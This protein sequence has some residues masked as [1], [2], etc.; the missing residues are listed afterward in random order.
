MATNTVSHK[1]EGRY[2]NLRALTWK[3][4]VLYIL[5]DAERDAIMATVVC[6][7]AE[8]LASSRKINMPDN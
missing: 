2:W 8:N 3:E 6:T 7:A 1:Q 5:Q 4:N